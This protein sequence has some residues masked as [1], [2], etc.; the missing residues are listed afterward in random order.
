M[1]KFHIDGSIVYLL[2]VIHALEGEEKKVADAFERV[3]PDCVAMGI[4]PEDIRLIEREEGDE[5]FEMSL[6]HQS[7]LMHLSA[8]GN[9]SIPPLDIRTAYEMAKKRGVPVE[10]VD[11]DDERYAELLTANVSIFVLIRHSRKVKKL[12]RRK[13]RAKSAEEFV[14]EWDRELNAIPSFRRIEDE[15]ERHMAE[16]V[17]RLCSHHKRILAIIQLERCKGVIRELER[18]K[19]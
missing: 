6:Q 17:R 9:I 8:Y 4:S 3:E 16:R 11:I 15:R 12:S 7:Y 2:P 19:K 1:E 10:A 18:Y 13:F 5:E 14:H